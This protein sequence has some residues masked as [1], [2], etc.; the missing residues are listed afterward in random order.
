MV[1]QSATIQGN[2]IDI[3][4]NKSHMLASVFRLRLS[5]LLSVFFAFVRADHAL[6]DTDFPHGERLQNAPATDIHPLCNIEFVIDSCAS[7]VVPAEKFVD[8]TESFSGDSVH[9]G[10]AI[11]FG[12]QINVGT[13]LGDFG[14]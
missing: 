12:M 6:G 10:E 13:F 2:R 14:V 3:H 7:D 1:S 11:E 4:I 9:D 5:D 8:A